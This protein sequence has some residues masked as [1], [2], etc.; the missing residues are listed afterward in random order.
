MNA[1]EALEAQALIEAAKAEEVPAG[2]IDFAAYLARID[3]E[4]AALEAR[5]GELD[6]EIASGPVRPCGGVPG[7]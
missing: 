2:T 7:S 1:R 5:T 3:A 6:G 4:R